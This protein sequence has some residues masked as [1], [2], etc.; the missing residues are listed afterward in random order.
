MYQ[1]QTRRD[2]LIRTSSAVAGAYLAGV[3]SIW[4]VTAPTAP[5][6]VAKCMTYDSAELLVVMAKMFDR[7][8]GLG[9]VA[10]GKTVA[11]KV[12]LTGEPARNR[13]KLGPRASRPHRT[14]V[15]SKVVLHH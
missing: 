15:D 1:I 14:A 10:K 4:T 6:A 7:I 9:R 5:V 2:W 11:V 8:G 13:R 12:N 3:P